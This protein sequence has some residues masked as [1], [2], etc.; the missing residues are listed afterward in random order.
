MCWMQGIWREGSHRVKPDAL[1]ERGH[2]CEKGGVEW[3]PKEGGRKE[4]L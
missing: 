1:R 3:N 2:R 4:G